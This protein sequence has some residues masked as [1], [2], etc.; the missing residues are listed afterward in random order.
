[1]LILELATDQREKSGKNPYQE[2]P[3]LEPTVSSERNDV[4]E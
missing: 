3:W 1:V 2:S 4:L